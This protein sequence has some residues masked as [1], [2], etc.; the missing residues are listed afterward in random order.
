MKTIKWETTDYGM[1]QTI[2]TDHNQDW[3]EIV[4]DFEEQF[5][6][7]VYQDGGDPRMESWVIV[8]EKTKV[9]NH[10]RARDAR[11]A[12]LYYLVNVICN[13]DD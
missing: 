9:K 2:E 6:V 10:L 12:C 13:Q 5:S 8:N 4:Y 7:S 3:P 11:E 1:M